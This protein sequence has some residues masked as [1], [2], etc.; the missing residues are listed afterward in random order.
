MC[1]IPRSYLYVVLSPPSLRIMCNVLVFVSDF[2]TFTK[3]NVAKKLKSAVHGEACHVII[4]TNTRVR[5]MPGYKDKERT[6]TTFG[7]IN[8]RTQLICGGEMFYNIV[9]N[10]MFRR[11][12]P[13]S[14]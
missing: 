4:T 6:E 10:Y 14:G 2:T 8:C 11:L 9:I 13:S 7:L 12:W 1:N 5:K 3:N